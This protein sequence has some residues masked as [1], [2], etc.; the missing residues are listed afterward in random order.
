MPFFCQVLLSGGA[1]AAAAIIRAAAA[2][3][4]CA[5]Y[6]GGAGKQ[7]IRTLT[8][9]REKGV[10]GEVEVREYLARVGFAADVAVRAVATRQADVV[11]RH[12]QLNVA[13]EADDGELAEGNEQLVAV[14]RQHK[15]IA[16]EAR[17]QRARHIAKSTAAAVTA[18]FRLDH[19][20]VEHDGVYDLYDGC[21]AVAV[22][23]QLYV[24]A[25]LDIARG[26][27]AC[28]A[29]A[30]EQHNA[31][32]KHGQTVDDT[33]P[34][35]RAADLA[36]DAIEEAAVNAVQTAVELHR[37]DVDLD[38]EQVGRT[39]L[40][41]CDAAGIEHIL[42]LAR[43]VNADVAQ[44][45]LAAAGVVDLARVYAHGL[46]ERAAGCGCAALIVERTGAADFISHEISLRIT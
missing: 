34:A 5:V 17:A 33:R 20:R 32:V 14:V 6:T 21:R 4:R 15:L 25:V 45:F 9:R 10:D 19:T 28:A 29:L 42:R 23:A 16:A 3:G 1:V 24:R 8:A 18:G 43:Q 37:L 40:Y 2:A 7:A 13:F 26:E 46:T 44:A 38:A 41:G 12:E 22:R 11:G 30:A 39:R 27:D 36:L 35:D 31:L